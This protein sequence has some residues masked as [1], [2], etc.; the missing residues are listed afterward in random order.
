MHPHTFYQCSSQF[1]DSLRFKRSRLGE[2]RCLVASPAMQNQGEDFKCKFHRASC[3]RIALRRQTFRQYTILTLLV[4]QSIVVMLRWVAWTWPHRNSPAF[5]KTKGQQGC[6]GS[7]SLS[8]TCSC[9][10]LYVFQTYV[11]LKETQ[12]QLADCLNLFYLIL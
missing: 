3:F 12:Q 1:R 8:E 10:A 11:V 9:Y 6:T 7:V 2:G 4:L 5:T